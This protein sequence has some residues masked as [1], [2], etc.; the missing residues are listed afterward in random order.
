MNDYI[1]DPRKW[2]VS[3]SGYSIKTGWADDKK[4]I[5]ACPTDSMAGTKFSAWIENAERICELYNATLPKEEP[6]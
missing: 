6:R 3:R 2:R 4:I 5:A 1:D